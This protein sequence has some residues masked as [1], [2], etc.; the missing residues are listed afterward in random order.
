MEFTTFN[1]EEKP[2]TRAQLTGDTEICNEN[3]L[4][5]KKE[6]KEEREKK[7]VLVSSSRSPGHPGQSH[8]SFLSF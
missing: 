7:S 1:S 5:K 4:L 6:R 3:I 8:L 2:I